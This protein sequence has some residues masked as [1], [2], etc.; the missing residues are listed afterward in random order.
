MGGDFGG[1][2][3]TRVCMAESLCCPPEAT[4]TSLTGYT[5]IQ[6]KKL[7]KE[8]DR[9]PPRDSDC[10]C[11]CDEEEYWME[12]LSIPDFQPQTGP[13]SCLTTL[14][15]VHSSYTRSPTHWAIL[16]SSQRVI[17][18]P[19]ASA[20]PR[21]FQDTQ[22]LRPTQLSRTRNS[23]QGLNRLSRWF[24]HT[25]KVKCPK[26]TSASTPPNFS[27]FLSLLPSS[28]PCCLIH[29]GKEA[30][31]ENLHQVP[32]HPSIS[33]PWCPYCAS[34]FSFWMHI[35]V[36]TKAKLSFCTRS[37]PLIP[38]QQSCSTNLC[39]TSSDSTGFFPSIYK[40]TTIFPT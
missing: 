23:G 31:Q 8:K 40:R 12:T 7:K 15:S 14:L 1:K 4:T 10:E 28:W 17:P 37:H 30:I 25:L 26:M 6:N 38:H 11:E 29:W 18:R 24:W 16:A 21:N 3:D 13:W 5:P 19:A 22:I 36:L 2:M 33:L 27:K 35:S 20:S 32:P 39:P 9:T 34:R